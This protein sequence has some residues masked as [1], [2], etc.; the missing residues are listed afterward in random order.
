MEWF[1]FL[2]MIPLYKAIKSKQIYRTV[3]TK[4]KE[5][6]FSGSWRGLRV[7]EVGESKK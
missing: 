3:K 4:S 5:R 6:V 2:G 1:L 7:T